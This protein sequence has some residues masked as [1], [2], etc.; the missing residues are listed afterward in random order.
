MP[1]ST[2]ETPATSADAWVGLLRHQG[3]WDPVRAVAVRVWATCPAL[4][5][6]GLLHPLRCRCPRGPCVADVLR[7]AACGTR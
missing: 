5:L 7:L 6:F 4:A 3:Q 2:S 1:R